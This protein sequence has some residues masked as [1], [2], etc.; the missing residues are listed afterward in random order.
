MAAATDRTARTLKYGANAIIGTLLFLVV[1]GA[2]NFFAGK[3]LWRADL[4]RSKQYTLSEATRKLLGN[5]NDLV[6]VTVFATENDTPADWNEQRKQLRDLLYEYRLVSKNKVNYRFVDPSV[7]PKAKSEAESLGI[8]EQAMQQAS[9]TEYSV[10][11]GYLGFVVQYKGK[12]EKVPTIVPESSLEYQLTRA[13]NKA[14]QLNIPTLGL[15]APGGN[16]FMGDGGNYTLLPRFFEQEGYTIKNLEPA[17]LGD[18]KDVNALFIMDTDEL[19]EEALYRIDQFVMNGGKLFVAASGVKIDPQ[20]GN[21]RAKSPNI[22]SLLENYGVRINQDIVED[23][24]RAEVQPIR[25]AR[26]VVGIKNPLLMSVTDL[27]KKS[28][29]TDKIRQMFFAYTSSVSP[30][31]HGTSATVTAL[32]QTSNRSQKQEQMYTL[33]PDK[34]KAPSKEDKL[35]QFNLVMSVKGTVDSRYGKVDPPTLSDDKGATRTVA[36]S[37]VIRTSKPEAQVVVAGSAL[38]FYDQALSQGSGVLNAIFLLNVAD[39]MT[40]GG[41]MISLRSKQVEIP[42]LKAEITET[43]TRVAQL[44][45]IGGVPVLLIALGLIKYYLNKLKRIRYRET[46]GAGS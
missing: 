36:A 19:S 16:P 21:A 18:L 27:D 10:K 2:I 34:L 24:A 43:E 3:A 31:E 9:S 38:S 26:G 23:W 15:V 4:T 41:D 8:R 45:V 13:I 14:A 25:T 22:N 29:I 44:L 6:N 11:A 35:E 12:S 7:D 17:K 37:E 30:S 42:A 5:L 39:V 20:T 32:A 28:P 40:R 1:L 46:Y 33:Q